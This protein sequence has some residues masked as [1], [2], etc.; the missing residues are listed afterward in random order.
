MSESRPISV[1]SLIAETDWLRRLARTIA[2]DA[3]SA[4]DGAYAID[5]FPRG[6]VFSARGGDDR[7]LE[8][9]LPVEAGYVRP[10]GLVVRPDPGGGD[11]VRDIPLKRG[12]GVR[13]VVVDPDERPVAGARVTY[14][15]ANVHGERDQAIVTS[16]A[17][18]TFLL[19]GVPAGRAGSRSP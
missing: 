1:E 8:L 11:V 15:I 6:T 2:G 5:G 13:G 17:D 7:V 9:D 3:V 18:G 4:D 19:P 12:V 14:H 16:A 10:E